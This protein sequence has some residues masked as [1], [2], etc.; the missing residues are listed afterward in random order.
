M[1]VFLMFNGNNTL[2]STVE[3]LVQALIANCQHLVLPIFQWRPNCKLTYVHV[4]LYHRGDLKWVCVVA[5]NLN[6]FVKWE[7]I[8]VQ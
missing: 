7:T 3:F 4:L 8:R 6:F 1:F 2:L 5:V